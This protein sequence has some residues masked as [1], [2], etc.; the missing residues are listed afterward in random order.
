MKIKKITIKDFRRFTDLTIEGI[1]PQVKLVVLLGQNGSGKSS[2]FDALSFV[3]SLCKHGNHDWDP[4][5]HSKDKNPDFRGALSKIHCEFHDSTIVYPT[6]DARRKDFYF[7]TAYRYDAIAQSSGLQKLPTILDDNHDPRR[8]INLDTRVTDNYQRMVSNS[9]GDLF[10]PGDKNNVPRISL[11]DKYIERIRQSM[12]RVF[13]DLLLEGPGRPLDDGTFL[14]AKGTSHGFKYMNL[15]GGEKAAFDLLADI[16]M[17]S[18]T[19]PESAKDESETTSVSATNKETDVF[20]NTV[21]CVDE[22]ELHIHSALQG[23]L[24]AEIV[25]ILPNKCQ[26]WIATHSVGMIRKA[27]ELYEQD[28]SSVAFLDFSDKNFDSQQTLRPV[29]PSRS[30]WKKAF[31]VSLGDLVTL[32]APK[33]VFL[34]EGQKREQGARRNADFDS[35]CYNKIFE[36]EF[37]DVQFVSVGGCH[38]VESNAKMAKAILQECVSGVEVKTIFDGDDRSPTE[39]ADIQ[40]K[41]GIVLSLRDIENYLWDDEVL[42]KLCVGIG[43]SEQFAS[44]KTKKDALMAGVTP[45]DDV[46][47]I[48]GVLYNEV[49]TAL[50]LRQCG[51]NHETF[52]R[53]TLAPLITPDMGVYKRLRKDIFGT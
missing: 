22:P 34:C 49:K 12:L 50:N 29:E 53:D 43:Q 51:N 4:S 18:E 35:K 41:G 36:K 32:L 40:A 23:K 21:Y 1:G 31:E 26:L 52:A 16:V 45:K 17:K 47:R 9:L 11:R 8:M 10:E 46:K 27:K 25:Q 39:V 48:T 5:Y 30:V 3:A 33:R 2:L 7:R 6:R 13:G 42:Q 28:P 37:P 44:V 20:D 15:S 24:L 19:K 14:F 38:D